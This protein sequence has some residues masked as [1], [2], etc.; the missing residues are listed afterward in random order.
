MRG[1]DVRF[2]LYAIALHVAVV[3]LLSV[4]LL[5]APRISGPDPSKAMQAIAVDPASVTDTAA[6]EEAQRQAEAEAEQQRAEE[7]AQR[8]AEAEA[9]QQRAEEEAQR[10]AEAEAEQQRAEEEAQRQA[11]AEAEQQRAAEEAQRQAEAEAERQRAAEEAQHQAEAE[12][13]R[14]AE[15]AQRQAEADAQRA[16]EEALRRQLRAEADARARQ[17]ALDAALEQ[18]TPAIQR[19]VEQAWLRPAGA[20][21]GLTCMLQVRLGKGGSVL[22]AQVGRSSGNA[23][24][25]RSAQQAVI[26]ASPL[27]LPSDPEIAAGFR[28]LSFRFQPDA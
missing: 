14:A 28:N 15:E 7:E 27:P 12:R 10:Q 11:E 24:F 26:K 16:R 22:G 3:M 2:I 8:Q 1:K 18:Y 19:R 23:A 17:Q 25:D 5:N 21:P 9:E 6:E 20:P 4:S 13:Q